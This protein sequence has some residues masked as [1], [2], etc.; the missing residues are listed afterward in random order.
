MN[1]R[2]QL[3][4]VMMGGELE[5]GS[6]HPRLSLPIIERIYKKM[7]LRLRFGSIQVCE[8]LIINGHHRF[9]ASKLANFSMDKV[10]SEKSSAKKRIE[11]RNVEL[12]EE[13]W[14]SEDDIRRFNEEDARYNEM[15]LEDLLAQLDSI[16]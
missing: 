4:E 14:D 11:W 2:D 12:V 13:D 3:L 5:L 6:T 7:K 8:G 16:N 10:P 9:L 1:L 15:N